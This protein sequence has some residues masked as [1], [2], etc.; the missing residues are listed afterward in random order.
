MNDSMIE[1][2]RRIVDQ[3]RK[4]GVVS[5]NLKSAFV[6]DVLQRLRDNEST[7]D[8]LRELLQIARIRDLK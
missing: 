5:Y 6:G 7:I 2:L 8:Q 3:G 1:Y 4:D